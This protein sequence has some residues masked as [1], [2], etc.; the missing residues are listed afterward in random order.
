MKEAKGKGT[1]L[2]VDQQSFDRT[3]L[4]ELFREDYSV[5]EASNAFQTAE[6]LRES[7]KELKAVLISAAM[8]EQ[9]E[10]GIC[11]LLW[12]K[13]DEKNDIPVFLITSERINLDTWQRWETMTM[14]IIEKPFEPAIIRRRVNNAVELYEA[15]KHIKQVIGDE[16]ASLRKQT[17][18]KRDMNNAI[19]DMLSSV[20]EF[21][22]GESGEHVGR[23]R[24][25]TRM[26]LNRLK[27][28]KI[29]PG[30][31]DEE[32]DMISEASAMHDIG[33]ISIPEHIL[34][35]PGPLTAEEYEEMKKHTLY[36]CAILASL[37]FFQE[38]EVFQ[39]AY[40]ICRHHHDRWDGTGYPDGIRGNEINLAA[41]VVAVADVYDSL[42]S[43][44]VYKKAYSHQKA[45]RMI[46]EGE[47]GSFNPKILKCFYEIADEA[48]EKLYSS[49]RENLL[50]EEEGYSPSF[51]MGSLKNIQEERISDKALWLLERERQKFTWLT[52]L[53]DE[54]LFDYD[55]VA[56]TI[57]FSEKYK[58]VFG[59][60]LEVCSAREFIK[61]SP[62]ATEKERIRIQEQM[63]KLDL[64]QPGV[65]LEVQLQTKNGV[66]WFDF[67]VRGI[68]SGEECVGYFGRLSSIEH[69]KGETLKWK[70]Q[71]MQDYLTGLCNR[72][73][74]ENAVQEMLQLKKE[75]FSLMMLDVD[76]FKAVNDTKGHLVGDE[77]LKEIAAILTGKFRESDLIARLGGDEF[78]AL[79]RGVVNEKVLSAKAEEICQTTA[80]ELAKKYGVDISCSI[81][82][83]F[84]P[85]DGE[86]GS[87]LLRKADKALY[88]A[89]KRGKG[90]YVFYHEALEEYPYLSMISRIDK[91]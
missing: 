8:L 50:R 43:E 29:Y 59:G 37:P 63:K 66:E 69:L 15:R 6:Y 84:Y 36:G 90:C 9:D 31:T 41:Q 64:D 75:V 47:C 81:G 91:G 42:V 68:W 11:G 85:A 65:S 82:F 22:S 27:E 1:L 33:K 88:E 7:A 76:N 62:Y 67:V 40:E 71:A 77:L 49:R 44:R 28:N 35:K 73:A 12:G 52:E 79:L 3:F 78:C 61:N 10:D 39:Y 45:I 80:G 32:I 89:K 53:S 51:S 19:I 86:E 2:I 5:E 87:L 16:L 25:L 48:H 56:D 30:L 21:R 34:N 17:Y 20:I 46:K 58:E 4:G 26:I 23:I 24:S 55:K 14:D 13:P 74:L 70:K 83:S 57:E 18:K 60:N 72:Q 38:E 54:I